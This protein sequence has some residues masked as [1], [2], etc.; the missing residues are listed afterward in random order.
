MMCTHTARTPHARLPVLDTQAYAPADAWLQRQQ[1]WLREL[2]PA[3]LGVAPR[4][5]RARVAAA[6]SG[7]DEAGAVYEGVEGVEGGEGGCRADGTSGG[8]RDRWSDSSGGGAGGGSSPS[9]PSTADAAEAADVFCSRCTAVAAGG[10]QAC[11]AASVEGGWSEGGRREGS[12]G[13]GRDKSGSSGSGSG[14]GSGGGSSS[15]GDGG[16]SSGGGSG[17][18]G[19]G[20]CCGGVG[21]PSIYAGEPVDGVIAGA[22]AAMSE[23]GYYTAVEDVLL[24]LHRA[25]RRLHVAAARAAGTT[26]QLI[27]ADALLPLLV[28]S[29]VHTPLPCGV[30]ALAYAQR[31]C[32]Q[33]AQQQSSELGYYLAC[34]EA[35]ISYVMEASPQS[36]GP[37]LSAGWLGR[38][39][40]P[41]A[42]TVGRLTV[43]RFTVASDDGGG[44]GG[45]GGGGG[46]GSD[47]GGGGGGGDS[48]RAASSAATST[49]TPTP[50]A[51]DGAS[52]ASSSP[53][54]R[55]SATTAAA[56]AAHVQSRT[57]ADAPL[58]PPL[59]REA[60]GPAPLATPPLAGSADD[61]GASPFSSIGTLSRHSSSLLQ[62]LGGEIAG[63]GGH[64]SAEA[65][66]ARRELAAFLNEEQ[67]LDEVMHSLAF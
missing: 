9:T 48:S 61:A 37:T 1:R 30:A 63:L 22:V 59:G 39:L 2:P 33:N 52:P 14:S 10:E 4:F 20:T 6:G 50:R 64:G 28:W 19:D 66:A 27:G 35:A 47:G 24:C 5:C 38:A 42:G 60:G 34:F 3:Q 53:S 13:E 31:L 44:G 15:G 32:A 36:L 40:S 43:L 17:S 8:T 25:M 51:S 56:A 49:R 65:I 26:P 46:G 16:G 62:P 7:G 12:R 29:V 67:Q 57:L 55:S 11:S 21:V 58:P 54:S 45:D 18:G 23:M 41:L